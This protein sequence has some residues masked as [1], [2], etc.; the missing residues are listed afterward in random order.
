M[1]W[2]YSSSGDGEPEG[3]RIG[4]VAVKT[5]AAGYEVYPYVWKRDSEYLEVMDMTYDKFKQRFFY[6]KDCTKEEDLTIHEELKKESDRANDLEIEQAQN[7]VV[8]KVKKKVI[9][10]NLKSQCN[11]KC[12]LGVKRLAII[13]SQAADLKKLRSDAKS[14]SNV[15]NVSTAEV[16][17]LKGT[18]VKLTTQLADATAKI[19]VITTGA[20]TKKKYDDLLIKFTTLQTTH[21]A[22]VESFRDEIKRHTQPS[23]PFNSVVPSPRYIQD[24]SQNIFDFA[25]VQQTSM[26]NMNMSEAMNHMQQFR[27]LQ[28]QQQQQ[29]AALLAGNRGIQQGAFSLF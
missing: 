7:S 24:M 27:N 11:G 25:P 20:V 29:M 9:A 12:V 1:F 16:I 14:A 22:T 26:M 19:K 13:N 18:V 10:Q 21:T 17:K 3:I 8:M 28:Q 5:N 2:H 15:T 4:A 23:I 6:A